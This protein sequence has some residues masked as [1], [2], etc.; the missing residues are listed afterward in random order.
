MK[1]NEAKKMVVPTNDTTKTDYEYDYDDYPNE[2]EN[3]DQGKRN[4]IVRV[5]HNRENPYVQINKISLW[6]I[7]L[8][9]KATGLWARCLSR[10]NNWT[11]SLSELIK[12]CK[13][14]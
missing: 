9:L 6:D 12:K 5:V 8:S 2:V 11:F 10:P 13:E 7:G 4:T 3:Y 1:N 14:G